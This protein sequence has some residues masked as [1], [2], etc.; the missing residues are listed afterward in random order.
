MHE[1]G[2]VL[3]VVKTVENFAI[4]NNVTTIEKLVLQIGELS[5]MIPRY[6]EACYPCAAEGTLLEKTT[7]VIEVLPGNGLCEECNTVFN[8][9]SNDNAC[10]KCKSRKWTVLSGKEFMIKEIVAC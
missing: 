10:P 3:D 8:L 1:L 6:V 9:I 5:S 2:I 7:L 4:K